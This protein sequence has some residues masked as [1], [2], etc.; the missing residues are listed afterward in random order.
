[1][2]MEDFVQHAQWIFLLYFVGINAGYLAQNV[3]A[4]M[5][6][7]KYLQ[8]SRQFEAQEVFST[9]DIPVSVIVPAYNEEASINTSIRALLQMDYPD[10]ELVV[11]NDGSKDA[12]LQTLVDAFGLRSFPEAYRRRVDCSE[13]R[14][15][16]RSLRYQNLRIIDKVNGGSKADAINAGINAAGLRRGRGFHIATG[17]SSPGDPAVFA[18]SKHHR[19]WRYGA[20]CKRLPGTPG[21]HGKSRPAPEFPGFGTSGRIPE[22]VPVRSHGMVTN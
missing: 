16:Y 20:H 19:R 5:G 18:G 11:V 2:N 4:T 14:G 17:Q 3:I 10:F 7:R 15:V 9:L 8:T 21:V 1:V 13:V 6:I 12:T 22:G